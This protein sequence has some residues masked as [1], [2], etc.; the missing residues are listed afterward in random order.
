M[1]GFEHEEIAA[2]L[3][4]NER[5]VRRWLNE[6][7]RIMVARAG[8]NFV[9]SAARRRPA[10]APPLELSSLGEVRLDAPLLW[11]DFVLKEQIGAGATG[12]VYRALQKSLGSD[13]AIKFLKKSLL[14]RRSA[15]L[16]LLREAAPLRK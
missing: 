14:G 11:S 4:C 2:T 5:T 8:G 9:P 3:N 15:I 12:K 6:A 10:S 1:Q 16:Q 13:V 7:R